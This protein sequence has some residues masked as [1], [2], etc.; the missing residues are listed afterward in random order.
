M[1]AA[2]APQPL[3]VYLHSPSMCDCL[4]CAHPS[5]HIHA[6]APIVC[7]LTRACAL[8]GRSGVTLSAST[9]ERC[10]DTLNSSA[11]NRCAHCH[12]GPPPPP[13]RTHTR[14]VARY[15]ASRYAILPPTCTELDALH[16][17]HCNSTHAWCLGRSWR[18]VAWL[19][20]ALLNIIVGFY[21]YYSQCVVV[22][23]QSSVRR[24]GLLLGQCAPSLISSCSRATSVALACARSTVQQEARTCTL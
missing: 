12:S 22:H 23:H 6:H 21:Y 4:H 24:F 10:M 3:I 14:H 11:V 7:M 19:S 1:R 20:V 13:P 18:V 17:L 8:C 2:T 9:L 15:A 16:A 5:S